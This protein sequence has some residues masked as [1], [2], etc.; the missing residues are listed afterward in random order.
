MIDETEA[1]H[2]L[3]VLRL[4]NGTVVELLDGL[5]NACLAR[6]R[7]EKKILWADFISTV[8]MTSKQN[9]TRAV[10]ELGILKGEAFEW[11]VE[12]CVELGVN[13]L[14]PVI[15]QH[16]VVD[17]SKK[18]S[19]FF[20]KRWQKIADQSLKQCGRFSRML[21]H[22]PKPLSQ[23]NGEPLPS[24]SLRVVL[25]EPSLQT[26][27]TRAVQPLS[28]LLKQ[29]IGESSKYKKIH[30]L[31]GPEG[32]FSSTE[33]HSTL[34]QA[35]PVSLFEYT[36]RAETAALAAASLVASERQRL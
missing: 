2:A 26:E 27:A 5:G 10:F 32:G 16:T 22:D 34:E 19:D 8:A 25:V 29:A 7:I 1:N 24:D 18:G 6:L 17:V 12:K 9:T 21:V 28:E 36:L 33:L 13:E 31:I 15:T 20:Q 3:N 4:T 30:L 23:V 35:S 14:I 11:V